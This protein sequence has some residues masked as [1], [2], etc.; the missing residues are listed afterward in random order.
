MRSCR[1][2]SLLPAPSVSYRRRY[3]PPIKTQT[4]KTISKWTTHRIF[5]TLEA[6][7]LTG[8]DLEVEDQSKVDV[9]DLVIA[10]AGPSGLSVGARVAKAGFSVCIVDP[11]PL[12]LWPNN[13][14]VWVDEFK[15]MGLE[16]CLQ[17]VWSKSEVF[18]ENNDPPRRLNRPYGRVDRPKLKT[19]LL[20]DCIDNGV[21][22]KKLKVESVDMDSEIRSVV[23]SNETVLKTRLVLDATGHSRKLIHYDKDFNPGYQGAYGYIATVKSHPFDTDTML[24]MDWRDSYAQD[25]PQMMSEAQE[26]PTFLYAM[27]FSETE[28]FLEETSLVCRPIAPFDQ[29]KE[30]LEKRIQHLNIEV[31][32]KREEEYCVIPM[33]GVLPQNPQLVLGIGGTA[34]MVHPSTGYMISRMLGASPVLADSIIDHLSDSK[35]IL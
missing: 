22:F 10:G 14:G 13:Y 34:G 16:D 28:I 9:F 29:L 5:A 19:R 6:N 25:D 12:S 3:A 17:K 18:L 32:E 26:I 2:H 35:P 27:P 20:Q 30:R 31:L 11:C 24:F 21:Y 23:C 7:E 15:A 8:I 1:C 33:G 4:V